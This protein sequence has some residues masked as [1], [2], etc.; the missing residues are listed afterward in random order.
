MRQACL[1][2]SS[3]NAQRALTGECALSEN[4]VSSE[5]MLLSEVGLQQVEEFAAELAKTQPQAALQLRQS[6]YAEMTD[7]YVVVVPTHVVPNPVV[8][9][10][11]GDTISSS[12][13]AMEVIGQLME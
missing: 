9:V 13:Y 7:H 3:A 2:G 10:G 12:A 11:M 6:G 4:I 8:T 5:E 1:Y